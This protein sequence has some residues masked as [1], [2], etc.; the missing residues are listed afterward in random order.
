MLPPNICRPATLQMRGKTPRP[1]KH[2]TPRSL[3]HTTQFGF[4]APHATGGHLLSSISG[5]G[6]CIRIVRNFSSSAPNS[7]ASVLALSMDTFCRKMFFPCHPTDC[8]PYRSNAH[9]TYPKTCLRIGIQS[10]ITAC[11]D[12][13]RLHKLFGPIGIAER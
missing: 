1:L 13:K 12:A 3:L 4:T 11:T 8:E 7:E 2:S 9:H 6:R 10:H 5:C